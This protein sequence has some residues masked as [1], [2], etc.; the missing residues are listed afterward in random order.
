MTDKV[1][2]MKYGLIFILSFIFSSKGFTQ[3][4]R[5][6]ELRF[7]DK[8][9][10][11]QSLKDFH[12]S[13]TKDHDFFISKTYPHFFS[14]IN[15]AYA[16]TGYNC[17]YAGW[18]SETVN[19]NGK[20]LCTSPKNKNAWYQETY[21][22]SCESSQLLCNPLLF[23]EGLCVEGKTRTQRIYSYSNCEK[24]FKKNK[25]SLKDVINKIDESK[26]LQQKFS[27]SLATAQNVCFDSG[28]Q[29]KT[30][31]CKI[32]M[33]RLSEID[34]QKKKIE[35]VDKREKT[36]KKEEVVT[37]KTLTKEVVEKVTNLNT[38]VKKINQ[39]STSKAKCFDHIKIPDVDYNEEYWELSEDLDQ[40][41]E[42]PDNFCHPNQEGSGKSK[43]SQTKYHNGSESFTDLTYL[44]DQ[45]TNNKR[46]DGFT[47]NSN[48]YGDPYTYV[49]STNETDEIYYPKRSYDYDFPNRGKEATFTVVDSPIKEKYDSKGNIIERYPSSDIKITNY[50]FFPRKKVPSITQRNGKTYMT[51]TTGEKVIF[52]AESGQVDGGAFIEEKANT[53]EVRKKDKRFYPDKKFSYQGEGI[54]IESKITYVKDEREPGSVLPIHSLVAGKKHTCKMKSEDLFETNK[55]SC[56]KFKFTTDQEFYSALKKKCPNFKFPRLTE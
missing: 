36:P 28:Y 26:E 30:G 40:T 24:L 19:F 34:G 49:E 43:Y 25:R 27:E 51:L 21:L 46:V 44:E 50:M 3:S 18:P 38:E 29:A 33:Q 32:L 52:N 47:I 22:N 13:Y 45:K 35:K 54:W 53:V 5:W 42:A 37:T 4:F 20:E 7:E 9:E 11:V 31:M 48:R 56:S 8:K 14:L 1:F 55:W 39:V 23:G 17:F 2:G 12:T 41:K 16:S 15:H 6:S 10:L